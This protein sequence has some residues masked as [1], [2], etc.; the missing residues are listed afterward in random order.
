MN[1]RDFLKTGSLMGAAMSLST[2]HAA[3]ASSGGL[4]TITYNVLASKG[5][6]YLD[7]KTARGARAATQMA[8]R[9]AMELDLYAPDI[10]TFQE[11]PEEAV[12]ARIAAAMNMKVA[13]FAG[14]FPGTIISR[15]PI[16]DTMNHS[17]TDRDK[18]GELFTRHYC[19]ATLETDTGDV[20][21][22]SAHLHPSSESVR[23]AE[24][25][26]IL[27]SI[28]PELAAGRSILF[29]GDLNH[30]PDGP[31]YARWTGAGLVD[32]ATAGGATPG[33]TFK[34]DAPERRIDYIWA[35]GPLAAHVREC[36]VLYEG[37]FRTNPEDPISFGLSDHL[38]VLARF[39]AG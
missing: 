3:T 5:Y 7:T 8:D 24:V 28:A 15:F 39:D 34:C 6:P 35:G 32:A 20:A 29:Q 12:S 31:E 26:T 25:S 1:R 23:E 21:L 33:L 14:G 13:W 22:F 2:A 38:P 17:S 30:T 36:R 18:P 11:S 16:R 19:R 10:V 9:I 37:A 4:T 27:E